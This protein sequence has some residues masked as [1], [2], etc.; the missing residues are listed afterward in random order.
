MNTKTFTRKEMIKIIYHDDF[1]DRYNQDLKTKEGIKE[2]RD[3][4]EFVANLNH[5]ELTKRVIE[6]LIRENKN[7]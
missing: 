5:K 1:N 6:I 2:D 4:Y 7:K 3:F